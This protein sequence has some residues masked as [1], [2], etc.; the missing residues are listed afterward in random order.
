[1]YWSPPPNLDWP[2]FTKSKKF[3]SKQSL[4]CR[5]QHL[6]FQ[7]FSGGDTPIPSQREGAIPSRTRTQHPVQ[8]ASAPV[9]GPKPWSRSTFQP[10]LRPCLTPDLAT[11]IISR[12]PALPWCPQTI[13]P[14]L[15]HAT[16]RTLVYVYLYSGSKDIYCPLGVY[17]ILNRSLHL[18]STIPHILPPHTHPQRCRAGGEGDFST[19]RDMCVNLR[20]SEKRSFETET[21]RTAS[22]D[23]LYEE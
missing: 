18:L 14:N 6:S 8:D 11:A 7:K 2:Q 16:S 22:P 20:L 1:M 3:H 17:S 21:T 5:I 15:S 10:W 9:L 19:L 13:P 12:E 23:Q 4:E